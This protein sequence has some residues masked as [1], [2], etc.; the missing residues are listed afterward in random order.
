MEIYALANRC[1]V[2]APEKRPTFKMIK[3]TLLLLGKGPGAFKLI[4]KELLDAM[5]LGKNEFVIKSLTGLI[6]TCPEL[7][8]VLY[9]LIKNKSVSEIA[10]TAFKY[11]KQEPAFMN[12]AHGVLR[13]KD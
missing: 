4:H 3:S 9:A 2:S 13:Y 10:D 8:K 12:R 11:L 5:R 6:L 7:E 1:C